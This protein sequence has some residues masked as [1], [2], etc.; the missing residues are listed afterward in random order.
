VDTLPPPSLL[1]SRLFRPS[2]ALTGLFV[3]ALFFALHE[4]RA[5]FLPIVLVLLLHFLLS[6]VIRALKAA[7]VPESLG[8][9]AVLGGLL[10]ALSLAGYYL[11]G[12]TREW[13]AQ[14]P[15]SVAQTQARLRRLLRPVAQVTR[16]AEQVAQ[17]TDVGTGHTPQVVIKGPS[18]GQRLFGTTES[19]VAGVVM[20]IV[21]LYF[22]LASGDLF[23]QKVIRSLPQLEDKKRAVTIAREAE[24]SVSRYLI[25]M[26]VI[27]AGQ[28]LLVAG[29][30][31]LLGVPTPLLWG[32]LAALL[33]WIPYVGALAMIT[34]LAV[35]GF[36][37][38]DALGQ[39]L[40]VPGAF[41][42]INLVIAN[43]VTPN[44]LGRRLKLNRVAI[45]L[46]LFFWSWI[47]GVPGAFVAV[48]LLATFKILCDHI[49]ALRP[50]GEFL[51]E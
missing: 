46:G 44:V 40:L 24:A 29:A 15:A 31:A 8:A 51:G 10:L 18:L 42:A 21:L 49:D 27:N 4:G 36:R 12:P 9:A 37:T 35:L 41:V 3:L 6:P 22:L 5:F 34:V 17:A 47:W 19:L 45:L 32:T 23:L 50:V 13:L 11:A 48:P 43:F 33:A 1:G 7:R 2:V 38:F 30:M 26:T 25:T 20:V 14:A 28:G 39:A 16:T